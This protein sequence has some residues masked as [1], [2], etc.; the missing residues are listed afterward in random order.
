MRDR[1]VEMCDSD[2]RT[3][4][5]I[6]PH[7]L[8]GGDGGGDGNSN[9]AQ[10][11]ML[12]TKPGRGEATR[13]MSCSDKIARWNVLGL[14]GALLAGVLGPVYLDSCV[15]SDSTFNQDALA[16]ALCGRLSHVSHALPAPYT[17]RLPKLFAS[18]VC[19]PASREQVEKRIIG[20]VLG[21]SKATSGESTG[22]GEGGGGK[23]KKGQK[24]SCS[25]TG[26]SSKLT[27]PTPSCA[28]VAIFAVEFVSVTRSQLYVG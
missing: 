6:V 26:S 14:Q 21:G 17:L 11:G 3:G 9:K 27:S 13:S 24:V 4:A 23:K 20:E 7:S 16:R 12:R 8:T 15:V 2:N 10:E 19:F 1:V 28:S 5:K 18:S 25:P 22:G